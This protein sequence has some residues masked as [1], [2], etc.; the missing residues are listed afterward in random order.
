M[1]AVSTASRAAS[2]T[3]MR[4]GHMQ[5]AC[6]RAFLC[7]HGGVVFEANLEALLKRRWLFE[8]TSALAVQ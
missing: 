1:D 7:V 5:G 8:T 3:E 6:D 4:A 2:R